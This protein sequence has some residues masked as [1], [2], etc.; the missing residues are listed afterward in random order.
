MT[1]TRTKAP[2][3]ARAGT[4]RRA[5][6]HA[7]T[8]TTAKMKSNSP[9]CAAD[10]GSGNG[11]LTDVWGPAQWHVLHTMSFNYPVRPTREQRRAYRDHVLGLRNVLPCG[12]CRENLAL[13]FARLPLRAAHMASRA[14]FSR[15]VYDLHELVN[16]MLG[17]TS[18]LS[19]EQV[20]DRYEEFRARCAPPSAPA[21]PAAPPAGENGCT[22]PILGVKQRCLILIV[23]KTTAGETLTVDERCHVARNP[24]HA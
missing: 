5:R 16:R 8:T 6:P 10:Y 1:K 24:N 13:N 21:A 19:Y 3:T 4:A 17:K 14:T 11:M 9:F 7:A 20:R 23:P 2:S 18:G 15:Y 12:K 22:E